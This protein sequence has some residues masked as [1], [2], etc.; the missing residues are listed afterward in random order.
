MW[1][2][3]ACQTHKPLWCPED[4]LLQDL[5]TNLYLK[6]VPVLIIFL[7]AFC[8]SI[9]FFLIL[10][11]LRELLILFVS[12]LWLME[13]LQ[14]SLWSV[15]EWVGWILCINFTPVLLFTCPLWFSPFI[16]IS[17]NLRWLCLDMFCFLISIFFFLKF[18]SSS[19]HIVCISGSHPKSFLKKNCVFIYMATPHISCG[20]WDSVACGILVPWPGIEPRPPGLGAWML[21]HWTI[22]EVLLNPFWLDINK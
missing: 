15:Q 4:F 6:S 9:F 12:S 3:E 13:S 14:S 7:I 19:W 8:F 16:I 11:T 2:S 17:P 1:W 20:M 5:L 21:S 18:F 10:R 22:K